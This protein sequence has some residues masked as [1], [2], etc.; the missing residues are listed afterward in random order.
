MYRAPLWE[1]AHVQKSAESALLPQ[2]MKERETFTHI[3]IASSEL[4]AC[5][6][7]LLWSC[8]IAELLQ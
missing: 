4:I 1:R 5:N 6:R 8:A 2:E 7:G 3:F